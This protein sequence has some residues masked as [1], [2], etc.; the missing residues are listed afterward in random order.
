MAD[1]RRIGDLADVV[2][3]KNAGPF[4]TT[5][6]LFFS[7]AETYELVKKSGILTPEQ[8]ASAYRIQVE[9]VL[10]VFFLDSAR[11]VK[12]TIVKPGHMASGDLVCV[13]T[14]GAQQYMPI[15]EITMPGR[16]EEG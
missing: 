9:D 13:D 3:S 6:D 15:M 10:G 12:A 1:N 11:G 4:L 5:I 16:V 7:D 14:F 8:I 2:R